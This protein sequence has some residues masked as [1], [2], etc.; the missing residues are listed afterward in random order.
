MYLY[1]LFKLRLATKW[2]RILVSYSISKRWVLALLLAVT[3]NTVNA[4]TFTVINTNSSGTGS[5][6]QALFDANN[7]ATTTPHLI[8]FAI[9]GAGVRTIKLNSVPT[10]LRPLVIDGFT[11]PGSSPNTLTNG[12]NANQLIRL[13]GGISQGMVFDTP[14]NVVRGISFV[15]WSTWALHLGSSNCVV[16][17]CLFGVTP[18]GT[19]I[20]NKWGVYVNG[21]QNRVGGTSP[22]NRVVINSVASGDSTASG[23]AFTTTA[24]DNV[25]QGCYIGTGING[26]G[27]SWSSGTGIVLGGT[28]NLIGGIDAGNVI[29]GFTNSGIR[30]NGRGHV[31]QGN[32][33][34]LDITGTNAFPNSGGGVAFVFSE[35]NLIGG[36]ASG[37]G[38]VI[39][40]N[41]GHG[42]W[43]SNSGSTNNVVQG[44]FIGTDRTGTV[45][46]GNSNFGIYFTASTDD[47]MVGGT[48]AGAGNIIAFNTEGVHIDS[49]NVSVRGNSIY[50]NAGRGIA[51]GYS[52][53][54]ND[55]N[56]N[57][58]G[59]NNRQNFPVLTN[60]IESLSGLKI[61]GTLPSRSNTTFQLD[62]YSNVV[63]DAANRG[64]GQKY[65]GSTNITTGSNGTAAFTVTVT[66]VISGLEISATATDP[67]G[68]TSE[69][70]D[71]VT[72]SSELPPRLSIT[73][74]GE[75]I[76][77]S[78]PAATLAGFHL[79]STIDLTPP[80]SWSTVTNTISND[81]TT[82]SVNLL[83]LIPNQYF[84]LRSE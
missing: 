44:N 28:N 59:P 13:E 17:G 7:V 25:I 23:V 35:N 41:I 2:L 57:D 56:D 69:F 61:Q 76:T 62:F 19:V 60:A 55:P 71:C 37:A 30:L 70:S 74:S 11:Q 16:E 29:C 39:S 48:N 81:G 5:F 47:N 53:T 10:L 64:E 51:L 84:R 6:L 31:I 32:R 72:A 83:Q 27:A 67:S 15:G 49:K 21:S 33:I 46:L 68:N 14:S 79:E 45:P 63:R 73:R 66:G 42:I 78:W 77:V 8:Q 58:I 38:N 26:S 50:S 52:L 22:E 43:V 34:G 36:L 80:I 1:S 20:P 82:K 24:R 12:N 65:L 40:G 18:A 9:P 54:V 75:Q 4:N 3:A